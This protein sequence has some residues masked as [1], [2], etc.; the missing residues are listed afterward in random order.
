MAT[1]R[2]IDI[3]FLLKSWS[4]WARHDTLSHLA[5]AR[6]TCFA[7]LIASSD[8]RYS[9]LISD[10]DAMMIDRAIAKLRQR[11]EK[12][13]RALIL[14]YYYRF[15]VS[16]IAKTMRIRRAKVDTLLKSAMFYVDALVSMSAQEAF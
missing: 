12:C 6:V 13:Y 7:K 3:D 14:H 15:S 1:T 4:V 9:C 2:N 10:D 16:K 11:D 8:S 5:H